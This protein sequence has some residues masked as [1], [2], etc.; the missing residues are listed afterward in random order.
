MADL[1]RTS[2]T[3]ERENEELERENEVIKELF[4]RVSSLPDS[5][6]LEALRSDPL[7]GLKDGRDAEALG[8]SAT[9]N[10]EVARIDAEALA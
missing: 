6:A 1:K 2:K 3:L 5:E 8:G 9:A 4:H 7:S 10:G